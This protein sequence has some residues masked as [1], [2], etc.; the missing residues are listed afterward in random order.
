MATKSILKNVHIKNAGDARRLA[1]ALEH[2]AEKPAKAVVMSKIVTEASRS[3][4]RKMF[5]V[6]K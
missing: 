4:I 1:N 3:D 5:A 2:A 6:E